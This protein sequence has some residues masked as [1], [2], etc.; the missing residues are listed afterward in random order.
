MLQHL[1]PVGKPLPSPMPPPDE[2]IG[3]DVVIVRSEKLD[4]LLEG[5]PPY[6]RWS[7][8]ED[9]ETPGILLLA[10]PRAASA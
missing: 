10:S 1:H 4:E 2:M 3:R 5:H 7:L 6:R 8:H 9:P